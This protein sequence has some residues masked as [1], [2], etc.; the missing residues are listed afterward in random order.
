MKILKLVTLLL[1][2]AVSTK[3]HFI[4]QEPNSNE[5]KLVQATGNICELCFFND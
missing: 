3:D 5:H 1:L 2:G 4:V